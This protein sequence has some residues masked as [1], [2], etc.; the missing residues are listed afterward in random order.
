MV[1]LFTCPN[2]TTSWAAML[3]LTLV[4]V[5]DNPLPCPAGNVSMRDLVAS[6]F[7]VN[8]TACSDYVEVARLVAGAHNGSVSF[9]ATPWYLP[10]E[11]GYG[12]AVLV[13]IALGV[14]SVAVALTQRAHLI[15]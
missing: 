3:L 15:R 14:A 2:G 8:C 6:E 12:D 1:P 11:L 7:G 13:F 5:E 10:L 4:Y 9:Q